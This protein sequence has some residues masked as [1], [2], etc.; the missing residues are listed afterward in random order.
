MSTPMMSSSA[1]SASRQGVSEAK[2]RERYLRFGQFQVDL[3]REELFKEGSRVRIPSKV[4][5]VLMA[6]IDRPGEVV[7]RAAVR[8][9]NMCKLRCECEHH[10]EQVTVG[11]GRFAGQTDVRRNNS[12]AGI[13]FSGK[14][15]GR[16]W[17]V[18][19]S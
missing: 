19:N 7:T 9:R 11:A 2:A 12:A 1:L 13:L 16:R 14:R 10:R 5:Q 17:V 3:Q 6:L 8:A 18:E 15:R 4:F